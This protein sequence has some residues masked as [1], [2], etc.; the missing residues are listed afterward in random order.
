MMAAPPAAWLCAVVFILCV[1]RQAGIVGGAAPIAGFRPPAVPLVTWDPYVSVW[2]FSEKL[3]DDWTKMWSGDTKA[4]VGLIRVDGVPYRCMGPEKQDGGTLPAAMDQ[5]SVTVYPTRSIFTFS[6]TKVLLTVVFATPLI[7]DTDYDLLSRPTSYIQFKVESADGLP[8]TVELYYDN[9]AQ[10]VV[11]TPVEEVTWDRLDSIDGFVLLRMGTTTQDILGRKGDEIGINWGYMYLATEE[12]VDVDSVL[13]GAL[14]CRTQFTTNG[15]LPSADD[16]NKPRACNDNW[17]VSALAWSFNVTSS[18]PETRSLIFAYDDIY[19]AQYFGT[20]LEPYWKKKWST[21]ENVILQS[22]KELD[23]LLEKCEEFD[24][25]MMDSLSSVGGD[26]YATVTALAY[27]QTLAACK[28]VIS[29][30]ATTPW[31]LMKEISSNGDFQTI[32]VI[33]PASPLIAYIDP[34]LLRLLLIPVLLYGNNE[35]TITYNSEWAPHH[36]GTYPIADIYTWQQEDMPIEESGNIILMLALITKMTGDIDDSIMHFWDLLELNF[37]LM[38][39]LGYFFSHLQDDLRGIVALSAFSYLCTVKGDTTNAAYYES[40]AQDYMTQWLTL[41]N[42]ENTDHYRLRYD[43]AG[44]SLKY[45]L[46]YQRLLDLSVFPEYVFT[47][48]T[49]YYVTQQKEFGVPLDSRYDFTKLDWET[50][51]ATQSNDPSYFAQLFDTLYNWADT[52]S[53]R[54]PLT[55]LYFTAGGHQYLGF[56][57]RPV[58]GGLF[59]P[60]LLDKISSQKK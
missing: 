20:N 14:D 19:S 42:P 4:M 3:T 5:L 28:I 10:M 30:D 57:A 52:T 51:I 12:S 26:K 7:Y 11:N 35:T 15:T 44:W 60:L 45:N 34:Q 9:T 46:V 49:A 37:L 24:L 39:S 29:P 56:Q 27:R 8:H 17:P 2:S 38:I 25:Q 33:F 21:I 6:D 16:S 47:M 48:E 32:D 50:W 41:A 31:Y 59:V 55:D 13:Y 36:I 53:A 43:E 23:D 18:V 22:W 54:V 1:G 40:V 58:V